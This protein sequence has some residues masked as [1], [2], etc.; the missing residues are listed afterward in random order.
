MTE[1]LPQRERNQ[2]DTTTQCNGINRKWK[3]PNEICTLIEL[4]QHYALGFN[5]CSVVLRQQG[6]C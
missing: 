4:Y 5:N 1:G 6:E 2:R 3:N